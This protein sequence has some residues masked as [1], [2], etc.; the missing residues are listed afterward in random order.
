LESDVGPFSNRLQIHTSVD[1]SLGQIT[2]ACFQGIRPNCYRSRIFVRFEELDGLDGKLSNSA[3]P[4]NPSKLTSLTGNSKKSFSAR[5][6][7]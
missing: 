1:K 4:F 3:S 2:S 6:W 5:N 7:L